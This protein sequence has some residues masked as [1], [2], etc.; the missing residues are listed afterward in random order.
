[1]GSPKLYNGHE[2]SAP[3]PA[4][5]SAFWALCP[6][7]SAASGLALGLT[8][9][10]NFRTCEKCEMEEI[11]EMDEMEMTWDFFRHNQHRAEAGP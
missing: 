11:E 10:V 1:M 6:A 9:L 2:R 5:S 7:R 4:A 8:T 3:S